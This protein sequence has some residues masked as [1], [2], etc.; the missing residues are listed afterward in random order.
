MTVKAD[1]ECIVL[2]ARTAVSLMNDVMHFN[3][4]PALLKAKTANPRAAD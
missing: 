3:L 4:C 2:G 1:R